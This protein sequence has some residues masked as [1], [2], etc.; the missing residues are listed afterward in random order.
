MNDT[1][2]YRKLSDLREWD[3]NPRDIQVKDFERLKKQIL[4][5]GQYKPLIITPDGTVL[6]GNMRLR[7]FRELGI[8]KIWVSVVT[9]KDEKQK[10]AY[11]LSDNERAGYYDE[12]SLANL[13]GEFQDFEWEN[14]AIDLK[15]PK[16]ISDILGEV[17][18]DRKLK[19][20]KHKE[21]PNCGFK[22]S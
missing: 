11:A 19:K 7:V 18:K 12:D 21:C 10:L 5:L 2:E 13:T 8:E 4:E 20:T 3:K 15:M 16:N 9:P 17:E 6:G 1:K 22:L 14:Y